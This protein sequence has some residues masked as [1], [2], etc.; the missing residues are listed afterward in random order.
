MKT[1]PFRPL[2]DTDLDVIRPVIGL[3]GQ[4]LSCGST[5]NAA[6]EKIRESSISRTPSF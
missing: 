3:L 5:A 1:A 2:A 6:D 4:R